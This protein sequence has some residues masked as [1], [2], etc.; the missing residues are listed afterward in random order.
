MITALIV[1]AAVSLIASAMIS[2][3]SEGLEVLRSHR[4]RHQF[5]ALVLSAE[6]G[7]KDIISSTASAT[8]YSHFGEPWAEPID[9]ISFSG[10]EVRAQLFDLGSRPNINNLA[11]AWDSRESGT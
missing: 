8:Q 6:R 9:N 5:Y 7:A 2:R 1:I 4:L 10:F 3:Q 11:S